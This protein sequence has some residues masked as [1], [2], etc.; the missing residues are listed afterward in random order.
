MK[1]M[2]SKLLVVFCLLSCVV[3]SGCSTNNEPTRT[4]V[5]SAGVSVDIPNDVNRVI[6]TSQNATEFMIAMGQRDKLIGVHKSLRAHT[7]TPEYIDDMDSL[8]MLGYSPAPEAVYENEADL[9]IVKNA[10]TAEELRNAGISAITFT[11]G[12]SEEMIQSVRMLGE[13]FGV[14]AAEVA[15]KWISNYLNVKKSILTT[16]SSLPDE[17]RK[18]VYFIDAS[19]ALDA[20][21]LTSTVGGD[22]IVAE[23]FDTIGANLV[24]DDFE[25]ITSITEEL[26]LQ[27]DPEVI[28]IGGWCENARKEQLLSDEKW[29][30][31]SA[32]R[33]NEIYLVPV[34]YVS[35]ERYAVEA[36]LLLRY[37]ASQLYPELFTYDAYS[38]FQRFFKDYYGADISHEQIGYMLNGLSPDGTRMD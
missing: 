5:D 17:D 19:G 21:G 31:V 32:V 20:G 11:Y 33:S 15:E 13:I 8:L 37:S 2:F 10:S 22:H 34:G 3:L 27:I 6:C 30:N 29:K 26:I 14:D 7:W 12:N 35:F 38:D 23:W 9:V 1:K 18:S 28:V 25:N 24:T 4:I 16:V 36:P